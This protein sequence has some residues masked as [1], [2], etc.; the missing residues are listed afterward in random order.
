MTD[1]NEVVKEQLL[2]LAQHRARNSVIAFRRQNDPGMH[3]GR[4]RA[5]KVWRAQQQELAATLPEGDTLR[6][7]L[8]FIGELDA[9]SPPRHLVSKVPQKSGAT[10]GDVWPDSED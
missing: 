10:L 1:D 4:V 5:D 9:I 6:G 3:E 2:R 7:V 8:E